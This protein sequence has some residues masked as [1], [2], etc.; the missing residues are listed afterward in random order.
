MK[1]LVFAL[2]SAAVVALALPHPSQAQAVTGMT[3]DQYMLMQE[4]ADAF[5]NFF[6]DKTKEIG[7]ENATEVLSNRKVS[8]PTGL[9]GPN[10][11]GLQ[12]VFSPIEST[13][14]VKHCRNL[15]ELMRKARQ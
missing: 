10:G 11:M 4:R 8:I 15:V 3:L 12:Y 2:L 6:A 1:K 13:A 7:L 14:L 5:C 9:T